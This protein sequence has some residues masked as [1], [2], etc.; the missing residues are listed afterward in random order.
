MP[1]FSLKTGLGISLVSAKIPSNLFFA[2]VNDNC[3]S[4]ILR[5]PYSDL[6]MLTISIILIILILNYID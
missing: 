3:S 1:D 5:P 6:D 4:N 2:S